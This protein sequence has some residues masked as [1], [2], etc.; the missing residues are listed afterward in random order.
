MLEGCPPEKE[1]EGAEP[2]VVAP[3][4]EDAAWL[5]FDMAS[6]N[7]GFSISDIEAHSKR[8]SNFLKSSLSIESL[9]LEA[10]I[11]P[12]E[13]EEEAPE[14]NMDDLDGLNMGDFDLDSLDLD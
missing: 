7:G 14:V 11:D 9:A 5:L 1:E 13:E 6:L 4:I 10:E 8:V 2:F 12:P 3:E